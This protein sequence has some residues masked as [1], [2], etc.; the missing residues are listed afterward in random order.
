MDRL[1]KS[2]AMLQQTLIK[3][4]HLNIFVI[5]CTYCSHLLLYVF[6][7]ICTY[8]LHYYW[9]PLC[10]FLQSTYLLAV[11]VI[12]TGMSMLSWFFLYCIF[13]S[14][15]FY[16]RKFDQTSQSETKKFQ[17]NKCLVYFAKYL[18]NH[19]NQLDQTKIFLIEMKGYQIQIN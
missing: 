5:L 11:Q 8:F 2:S 18:I 15:N 19:I 9:S 6:L 17:N 14:S 13:L 10:C 16:L 12:E 7:L 1:P 3:G 4:F